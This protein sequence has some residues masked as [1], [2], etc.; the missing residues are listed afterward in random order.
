VFLHGGPGLWDMFGALAADL[1]DLFTTY[2]WDQ[3]GCG[4]SL[5]PG[6]YTLDR[7]LADLDDLL[8]HFGRERV[9]LI[10]HS[11]G[12]GLALRYALTRPDRVERLV[13]L[14]GTG[15]APRRRDPRRFVRA[16]REAR[17]ERSMDTVLRLPPSTARERELLKWRLSFG[18][19][20]RGAGAETAAALVDPCFPLN[21]TYQEALSAATASHGEEEAFAACTRLRTPVL[22]VHG[23][24]DSVPPAATDSLVRALPRVRRV[25]LEE[26]GHYPWLEKPR[27]TAEAVREFLAGRD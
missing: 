24:Q 15:L 17:R 2:R 19:A 1:S 14:S 22:V 4:R 23:A 13:H 5:W 10:G 27:E 26:V 3:R 20:Q 25:V 6:P 7:T 18:F 21:R 9:S 8:G 16:L 12:A 11:W